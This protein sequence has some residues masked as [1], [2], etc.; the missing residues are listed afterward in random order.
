MREEGIQRLR[1]F[2]LNSKD[3]HF[4]VNSFLFDDIAH[5]VKDY[6]KGKVLDV[7]CGN[8]PYQNLFTPYSTSYV[9]CDIIQSSEKCVDMICPA[10]KLA[11]EDSCFDTVFSSQVIEHVEDTHAMVSELNR[12]LVKDGIVIISLPFAWQLHEEP[13]DFYRFSKYGI[14][15]LMEVKGFEVLEINANGGKWATIFQL[16]LNTLL[17]TRRFR[18]WRSFLI[19]HFFLSLGFIRLYNRF[20]VWLDRRHFDD[21]ITLNYVVVA[22]KK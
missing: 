22:R 18:T 17:S 9:G 15:Y 13:H 16:Y 19:K 12:V 10:T 14:R 1:H 20:A 5:A 8:K 3:P 2:K 21:W 11:F 4:I 6:A 7:G